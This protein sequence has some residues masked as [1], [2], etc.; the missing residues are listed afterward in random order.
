MALSAQN[1][2][3]SYVNLY[4]SIVQRAATR[5]FKEYYNSGEYT[6]RF[7]QTCILCIRIIS[8]HTHIALVRISLA[9]DECTRE[10][11]HAAAA[12]VAIARA[13]RSD[14]CLFLL[15]FSP[16][17]PRPPSRSFAHPRTLSLVPA[18]GAAGFATCA[19]RP[20]FAKTRRHR[21]APRCVHAVSS[22]P[23]V[24]PSSLSPALSPAASVVGA[25]SSKNCIRSDAISTI[26]SCE[27]AS[28]PFN[29]YSADAHDRKIRSAASINGELNSSAR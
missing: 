14:F 18:T 8:A 5:Y 20:R 23:A 10:T 21:I 24:L 3:T 6:R 22:F 12:A 26:S 16:S 9:R 4:Y 27:S 25:A 7:S 11:S 2:S 13:F 19:S 1:Q 17:P 15:L 29:A 28:R